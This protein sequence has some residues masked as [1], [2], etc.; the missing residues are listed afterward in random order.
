MNQ[1]PGTKRMVGLVEVMLVLLD[2]VRGQVHVY[3][4]SL[5]GVFCWEAREVDCKCHHGS[6]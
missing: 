5:G 6:H 4:G 1:A 3:I 2:A